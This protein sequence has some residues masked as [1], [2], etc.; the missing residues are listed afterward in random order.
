MKPTSSSH[1]KSS[2]SPRFAC[3]D[4]GNCVPVNCYKRQVFPSDQLL[5]FGH[6]LLW[7]QQC[8]ACKTEQILWGSIKRK[9]KIPH[10]IRFLG[11][12]E[13]YTS[14]Q[15]C[16]ATRNSLTTISFAVLLML[17]GH[18]FSL[19]KLSHLFFF[20]FF[21]LLQIYK[22]KHVAPETCKQLVEGKVIK[23]DPRM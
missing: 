12:L 14:Q 21:N 20:F 22:I 8:L 1:G 23:K 6:I 13:R 10:R 17:R 18:Y 9:G 11:K 15:N 19:C 7:E 4:N 5:C 2:S 16:E 3:A